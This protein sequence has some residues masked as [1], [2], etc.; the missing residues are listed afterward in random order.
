MSNSKLRNKSLKTR[1]KESKQHFNR[2]RNFCVSLLHKN[3]R[4]SFGKLDYRVVSQNKNFW[5]T[6]GFLFSEKAFHKESIVSNDSNKTVNSNEEVSEIFN[7]NF[8]KLIENLDIDKTLA[9]NIASFN[10][11]DPVFN[12]NRKYENHPNIR[13]IRISWALKI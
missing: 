1:K 9:N 12:A 5:K 7:Q 11:T 2:Q 3:K 13:K 4:V 8:S 6:V 10:I